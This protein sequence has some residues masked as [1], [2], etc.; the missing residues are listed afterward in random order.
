MEAEEKMIKRTGQDEGLWYKIGIEQEGIYI[1]DK[2]YLNSKNIDLTGIDPGTIKIYNNGGRELP[3]DINLPRPEGLIEN[4]IYVYGEGDGRFDDSDFILFYGMPAFGWDY[5]GSEPEH[6]INHYQGENIYLLTFGGTQKGKRMKERESVKDVSFFKPENF[7]WR[8]FV[9]NEINNIFESGLEWY[10]TE[11]RNGYT[12]EVKIELPGYISN[13]PI[14]YK[15]AVK[16]ASAGRHTFNIS[17]GNAKIV[18]L[19]AGSLLP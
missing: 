6:Y 9:E 12:R 16:G 14:K 10:G 13:N 11:F 5:S 15:I 7:R 17:E 3:Y 19:S 1:L 4:S 2:E 18:D 8:V